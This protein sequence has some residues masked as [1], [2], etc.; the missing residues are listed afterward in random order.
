MNARKRLSAAAESAVQTLAEVG[1]RSEVT[2]SER[3]FAQVIPRSF[4]SQTQKRRLRKKRAKAERGSKTLGQAEEV[5]LFFCMR[6][7]SLRAQFSNA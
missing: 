7:F 6:R 4:L 1:Y 5:E 3:H 2:R